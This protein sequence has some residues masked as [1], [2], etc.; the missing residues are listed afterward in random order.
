MGK[1]GINGV[2]GNDAL[3]YGDGPLPRCFST[4]FFRA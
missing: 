2:L 3:V 4:L 1:T